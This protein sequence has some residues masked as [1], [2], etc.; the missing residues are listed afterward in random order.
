MQ[1]KKPR[2]LT[3]GKAI[4]EAVSQ[5]MAKNQN[6]F[7][8]GIDV[9]DHVGIQ[10]TTKGLQEKYGKERVF[11]T[12]LSEDAMAGF[13]VGAAMAGMRPIHV[14][15]RQ[16]FLLLCMNQ[17]INMAAKTQYMYGGKL[18]APLV[19]RALADRVRAHIP[20]IRALRDSGRSA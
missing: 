7:T 15:I 13:A 11:A 19:A 20:K 1:S 14:H 6:V 5:E 18:S 4:H 2:L 12:P 16:A 8:F 17:L 10:G 9:D 3:Y